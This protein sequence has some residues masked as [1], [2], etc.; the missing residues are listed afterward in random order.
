[1]HVSEIKLKFPLPKSAMSSILN[2][3]YIGPINRFSAH[4]RPLNF[5]SPQSFRGLRPLD[6]TGTLK[7]A[8]G[9]HADDENA[10][11]HPT[12]SIQN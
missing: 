11:G 7:R 4:F 12:Q 8:P 5:Q 10:E 2:I 1:M 6:P 9:P 3:T